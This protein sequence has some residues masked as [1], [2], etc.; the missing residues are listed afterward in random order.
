MTQFTEQQ[1]QRV[2][3][4]LEAV[5]RDRRA[6][7]CAADLGRGWLNS[8]VEPPVAYRLRDLI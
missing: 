4:F 8:S 3:A 6:L 2:H 7:A 1:R 5:D